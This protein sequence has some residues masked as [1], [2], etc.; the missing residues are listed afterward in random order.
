MAII[1]KI[2][3]NGQLASS[4]GSIL[5]PS[6]PMYVKFFSLFNTGTNTETVKV[7]VKISGNS[8]QICQAVL[9]PKESIRI[10]EKDETLAL[11]SAEEIEAESTNANVVD[12]VISGGEDTP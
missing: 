12:Y 7:Y 10:I 5:N 4:K 6:N 8:R 9:L 2:L 1:P 3:A 11:G